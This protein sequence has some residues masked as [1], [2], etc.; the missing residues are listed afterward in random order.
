MKKII[1]ILII[2]LVFSSL[3]FL[4]I[5][6]LQVRKTINL[7]KSSYSDYVIVTDKKAL[8]TKNENNYYQIGYIYSNTI[9]P[10]VKKDVTSKDD[11]YYQIRDSDYY[12]DYHNLKVAEEV[13][14]NDKFNSYVVSNIIK[15]NPT[16]LYQD[17]NLK[18]EL[19]EET[20][21]DIYFIDDNKY[22][23]NYLNQ[24]F[25]ISD[26]YEIINKD[27]NN[28]LKEISILN[29]HQDIS[30]DKLTEMLLYLKDNNYESISLT[31]FKYWL[32]GNISLS[33]NKVLLISSEL[34][35]DIKE[36]VNSYNYLVN[37]DLNEINFISGDTK[38][39]IG[40]TKLYSYD[41]TNNTSINRFSDILKGIKE[42]TNT[43]IAVLNYHFFYDKA[44]GEQCNESICLDIADFK[45]QLDYLKENNYKTLTMEEFNDWMDRKLIIPQKS[46]LI[47]IDDGAMGTSKINGNKIIPI[48][49]EYKMHA[50]LF[51]I[52]GWWNI[53]DYQSNYLELQS[54]GDELHHNNYCR[55]GNCSYKGLMLTKDELISDLTTSINK[56]GT[57]LAFCYPFYQKNNTMIE[58]LK[59]TNFKLAFGGGNKK[60]KQSDNK[61]NIPRYVVYK[62][63]SLDS[64]I[65]MIK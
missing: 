65:K 35:E 6:N 17:G 12:I 19:N 61:Y 45:K 22:Y 20:N 55:N 53:N 51:L 5:K 56:L 25:Y 47:T 1:T 31:D 7:I 49:E 28:L 14:D 41:I 32:N 34:E 10:L 2:I 48:L 60:V 30:K 43:Q 57:N 16:K 63:T 52:T 38:I 33:D 24:I 18:I 40:D 54:H 42:N 62:N 64:F 27:N 46:V 37:T 13:N 23:I 58:A 21:F 44:N 4:I 29:F 36:L 50:T 15:S 11:V 39:K 26:N 3:G 9:L 59:E 8:Y